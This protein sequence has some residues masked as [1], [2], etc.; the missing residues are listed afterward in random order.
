MPWWMDDEPMLD[1]DDWDM[2]FLAVWTFL[3]INITL[4]IADP[5][6]FWDYV[7]FRTDI[8]AAGFSLCSEMFFGFIGFFVGPPP[9]KEEVQYDYDFSNAFNWRMIF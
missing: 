2:I 9:P 5:K 1:D 3:T 8:I 7:N 4:Y 6:I